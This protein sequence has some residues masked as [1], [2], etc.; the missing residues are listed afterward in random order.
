MVSDID[1]DGPPARG[2]PPPSRRPSGSPRAII[3]S[4]L[5]FTMM[6]YAAG[7]SDRFGYFSSPMAIAA[8][9]AWFSIPVFPA[10]A[11]SR[12]ARTKAAWDAVAVVLSLMFV[13]LKFLAL[14]PLV[15]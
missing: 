13:Y 8:Y 12:A 9:L 4:D 2:K 14:I 5:A 6:A 7:W 1:L 11:L 10:V 3:Y 15:Q